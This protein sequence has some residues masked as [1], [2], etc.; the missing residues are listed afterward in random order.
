MTPTFRTC[1]DLVE[2]ERAVHAYQLDTRQA[3][4]PVLIGNRTDLLPKIE[5]ADAL[6]DGAHELRA[7]AGTVDLRSEVPAAL[8]L[9][10]RSMP[11]DITDSVSPV[12]TA[13]VYKDVEY[14]LT[15]TTRKSTGGHYVFARDLPSLSWAVAKQHAQLRTVCDI[16]VVTDAD[17][18]PPMDAVTWVGPVSVQNT[19]VRHTLT[20]QAWGRVLLHGNG[21]DDS[22]NLGEF[23]ICGLRTG[24]AHDQGKFGPSCSFGQGC[25]KPDAGVIPVAQIICGQLA[26]VNCFSGPASSLA[27]YG[28]DYQLILE[29]IEGSA[30]SIVFTTTACDAGRPE[31]KAWIDNPR[32]PAT[33]MNVSLED[34]NPFPAFAQF[35]SHHPGFWS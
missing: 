5:I 6:Y 23:T 32:K 33:A 17:E 14:G 31:I 21:Q 35:G 8:E 29:A 15:Q 19:D 34:V 7:S 2:Y 26:L 4:I 25:Y 30:Q 10:I 1:K 24:A 18:L 3:Q 22:L 13:G 28:P 27:M 9:M 20:R 12:M 16:L 11:G